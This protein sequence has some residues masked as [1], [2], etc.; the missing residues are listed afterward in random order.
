[1]ALFGSLFEGLGKEISV[2]SPI[3]VQGLTTDEPS[4]A[5][6][7]LEYGPDN[8]D[9]TDIQRVAIYAD[10]IVDTN[11]WLS[12]PYL[13]R[14]AVH[15]QWYRFRVSVIN[16][17]GWKS[18]TSPVTGDW[19][20]QRAGSDED[21][22]LRLDEVVNIL[23]NSD[24]EF[25]TQLDNTEDLPYWER[26]DVGDPLLDT[27]WTIC[28]RG[29]G[30]IEKGNFGRLTD[31]CL[32][33]QP[34][35]KIRS[36]RVDIQPEKPYA[37]S[38]YFLQ[39]YTGSSS[40]TYRISYHTVNGGLIYSD[41]ILKEEDSVRVF[42]SNSF[43]GGPAFEARDRRGKV[44]IP[45]L[46]TD[47]CHIEIINNGTADLWCDDLMISQTPRVVNYVSWD[48]E[49]LEAYRE[50]IQYRKNIPPTGTFDFVGINPIQAFSNEDGSVDIKIR[51]NYTETVND[52][53]ATGFIVF[54]NLADGQTES[55]IPTLADS[56]I[57]AKVANS[58]SRKFDLVGVNP[59]NRYSF[60]VCAYSAVQGGIA[61]T[62]LV[63]FQ[64]G[65]HD[66]QNP[67]ATDWRDFQAAGFVTI[68]GA[69][70][71]QVDIINETDSATT[72]RFLV[73]SPGGE[74]TT[75]YYRLG[76][77]GGFS[78]IVESGG[79]RDLVVNRSTENVILQYYS[80]G[81]TSSLKESMLQFVIDMNRAPE[82]IHTWAEYDSTTQLGI[83]YWQGD[84]DVEEVHWNLDGGATFIDSS[85]SGNTGTFS[86][87]PGQTRVVNLSPRGR[88]QIG[89][90][91]ATSLFRPPEVPR[92]ELHIASRD[93]DNITLEFEVEGFG[94]VTVT[95]YYRLGTTGA[96]TIVPLVSST[97]TLTVARTSKDI[98]LQYYAEG[99]TTGLKTNIET[100]TIDS[101]RVPEIIDTSLR[102]DPTNNTYFAKW[103]LDDDADYAT[104]QINSGTSVQVNGTIGQTALQGIN[105]GQ[106][107]VI[108]IVPWGPTGSGISTQLFATLAAGTTL[109]P[110]ILISGAS[111]GADGGG[112][113]IA[114]D[115]YSMDTSTNLPSGQIDYA[116]DEATWTTHPTSYLQHK[117]YIQPGTQVVRYRA[118][119]GNLFSD[120]ITYTIDSDSIPRLT[121]FDVS[122]SDSKT[123]VRVVWQGDDDV[124]SVRI[125]DEGADVQI[126][127]VVSGYT[128]YYSITGGTTK[129]ISITPYAGVGATGL[130]GD[131][132]TRRIYRPK[133][134][135]P[136]V[137]ISKTGEASAG[138]LFGGIFTKIVTLQFDAHA[139]ATDLFYLITSGVTG[140][141]PP[142]SP[143]WV[144]I[145]NGVTQNFNV[146]PFHN[147]TVQAYAEESG[148]YSSVV[149]FWL[150]YD[151][152]PSITDSY[153]SSDYPNDRA[154][155]F[156][157]ADDDTE[158]V[159]VY[160]DGSIVSS[161]ITNN[162]YVV[163]GITAGTSTT[164]NIVPVKGIYEFAPNGSTINIT[165]PES[166][167]FS[168]GTLSGDLLIDGTVA[169]TKL[170]DGDIVA[171]KIV[172]DAQ[173]W[174]SDVTIE[175]IGDNQIAWGGPGGMGTAGNFRFAGGGSYTILGSGSVTLAGVGVQQWVYFDPTTDPN[176]FQVTANYNTV[177]DKT[178]VAQVL[179]GNSSDNPATVIAG[180]GMYGLQVGRQNIA[181]E[182]IS[183]EM[184]RTGAVEADSIAANAITV[185]KLAAGAV[186]AAKISVAQ[187]SQ[188]ADDVGILVSGRLNGPGGAYVDLSAS[189]SNP[190]ISH[191][192]FSINADGSATFSGALSAATG[193][194][195]GTLSAASGT[196]SGDLTASTTNTGILNVTGGIKTEVVFGKSSVF[197][198]RI[199]ITGH[200]TSVGGSS[201]Y[202][203]MNSGS[204]TIILSGRVS[205]V[206]TTAS[207]RT[208]SNIYV[209]IYY[210][211][212]SPGYFRVYT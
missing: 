85:S 96:F 147:Y 105:P 110:R 115:V 81:D 176:N 24:F 11:T 100:F 13:I 206:A 177:S 210:G 202:I 142:G 41:Y 133:E 14:D 185:S 138:G 151:T 6:F 209:P 99:S 166:A 121:D 196:F 120:T 158:S 148:S 152:E 16:K 39:D 162:Q 180:V 107:D 204:S 178:I 71:T 86:M 73:D 44:F 22:L 9:D 124:A 184:I 139:D 134:D 15:G 40:A 83:A 108:D 119:I 18:A 33:L 136:W 23:P 160:R 25:D 125:E 195:S 122:L 97:R 130:A 29:I 117:V 212:G 32:I 30:G 3:I 43:P 167:Q 101:D 17:F 20:Y 65:S 190:F 27:S 156:W 183:A 116:V 140:S 60:A 187:L 59:V 64:A 181:A 128:E 69:P 78:T 82:I 111:T 21:D 182:S 57:S 114:I 4:F 171:A 199:Q 191:S 175:G 157:G 137:T 88:G 45:P 149:S 49:S 112:G 51:W 95:P 193:T 58:Q 90:S 113:Y 118:H 35:T 38:G 143:T 123:N 26:Y 170:I 163:S 70:R 153:Y 168:S 109:P 7:L 194:F 46:T 68:G 61:Y 201:A 47:Y 67:D 72:L 186:T 179:Q 145:G 19:L 198:T 34:G 144:S 159:T 50:T 126:I 2:L 127:N 164:L 131:T 91:V 28:T 205:F 93:K 8:N 169:G 56:D 36:G 10:K 189:G 132:Q 150:D 188:I 141:T 89:K 31:H 208:A 87:S 211:A 48:R 102:V 155:V 174:S 75:T 66:P 54:V 79:N 84:D 129:T 146:S 161:G 53:P 172:E 37:I 192:S 55:V 200:N 173:S 1:M 77:S 154:T 92:V 197:G 5:F 76:T 52:Y 42:Q 135:A 103:W 104:Y 12:H 62:D 94:D 80:E 207:S 74:P 106:V 165:R 98:V 63:S 203:Q